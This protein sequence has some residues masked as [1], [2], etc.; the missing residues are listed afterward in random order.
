MTRAI[1]ACILAPALMSVMSPVVGIRTERDVYAN[2]LHDARP[3]RR[4][5]AA[6]W[7]AWLNS[8]GG[9]TK[10]ET[11]FELE[12]LLKGIACFG[13]PLNHP[14]RGAQENPLGQDF[15]EHLLI[16]RDTFSRIVAL[17]KALLGDRERPHDSMRPLDPAM[18][19]DAAREKLLEGPLEPDTPEASL[20]LLRRA[21]GHFLDLAD[22]LLRIGPISSRLYGALHAVVV[23]EIARHTYFGP[24]RALEFRP[25]F[26]RIRAPGVLEALN[27]IDTESARP[28]VAL[29]FLT[30][31]RGLRYLALI[32]RYAADPNSVRPAYVIFAALRSDLRALTEFLIQRSGDAFAE[33]F[34]RDCREVPAAEIRV[35]YPELAE[36]ASFLTR[37]RSTLTSLGTLLRIDTKRVLEVHLPSPDAA[38]AGPELGPR[39]VHAITELR[40]SIHHAI[41]TLVGEIRPSNPP[42]ELAVDLEARRASSEHLRREVW[43]FMQVLRAFLAKAEAAQAIQTDDVHDRWT[44]AASVQFVRD[45]LTHFRAIGYQ[46]LRGHDVSRLEA[47][48]VAFEPLRDVDLF[49]PARLE[50]AVQE[51]R[52]CYSF[53]SDLFECISRRPELAGCPFD[54]RA[55]AETLKL[56]LGRS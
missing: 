37:I 36:T 2:L 31:F 50:K 53:L 39:F 19:R 3:L 16:L 47:F 52:T 51:C 42:C 14:S 30:L 21:F 12:I 22:G 33:G 11:L 25:E 28:V 43:M 13:H 26:D 8:L 7:D 29:T 18:S 46:L 23:R 38:V 10:V 41:H 34:E 9:E 20:D 4:D 32:E 55:A 54:R 44:G 49:D 5:Q 35:R 27:A 17:S 40:A 24:H 15:R 1:L 45:F 56:Y 48:L 6:A